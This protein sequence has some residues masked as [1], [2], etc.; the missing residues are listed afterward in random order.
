MVKTMEFVLPT[1][2]KNSIQTYSL[3]PKNSTVLD[4]GGG[5][6]TKAKKLY[7]DSKIFTIDIKNGWN[8]MEKGLP[9]GDWDVILANHFIEHIS[10]PDYFLDQCKKIMREN[11]ILD[12]GTPNLVAWFNRMTFLFGYIPHSMELS[13]KFNVG[14]PFDWN[15]EELGG[16][17]YVHSLRSLKE[18][19]INH[20]FEIITVI[21][22][23]STFKCSPVILTLDKI[24]TFINPNLS[25]AIR[26]KCTISS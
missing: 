11:T 19:L 15:N 13:T 12:I 8:V 20:G 26:V 23:C 25:S 14:K 7:P 16:H 21:G 6:G 4:V 17:I 10:N 22:E 3:V 1:I 5:D 2:I 24:I 18:L 9:E